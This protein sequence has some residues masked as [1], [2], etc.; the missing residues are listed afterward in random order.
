MPKSTQT[1]YCKQFLQGYQ[2]QVAHD[3]LELELHLEEVQ[4]SITLF[5]TLY[6]REITT[7]AISHL[8]ALQRRAERL[9][10]LSD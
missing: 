2:Q 6:N 5:T 8:Q 9:R 4:R 1:F 3:I 10:R 7:P